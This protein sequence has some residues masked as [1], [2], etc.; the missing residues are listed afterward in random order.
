MSDAA[1]LSRDDR[2]KRLRLIIR[3]L[4]VEESHGQVIDAGSHHRRVHEMLAQKQAASR[5]VRGEGWKFIRN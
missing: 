1:Y 4:G 5:E 3:V 2:V